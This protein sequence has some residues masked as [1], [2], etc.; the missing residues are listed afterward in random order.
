MRADRCAQRASYVLALTFV[1]ALAGCG[2]ARVP[3]ARGPHSEVLVLAPPAFGAAIASSLAS[4]L[5]APVR[6]QG[7]TEP[8]FQ[9]RTQLQS[10]E[11]GDLVE[12][13]LVLVTLLD[14]TPLAERVRRT[15]PA[16]D[17]ERVRDGGAGLFVYTD[18]WAREQVVV[19]VAA[20]RP[21]ALDSLVHAL[22]STFAIG[23]EAAVV[24]R[25]SQALRAGAPEGSLTP[26]EAETPPVRLALPEGYRRT[27]V[28]NGWGAARSWARDTPT[29]IVTLFW[30]DGVDPE[31]ASSS[32]FLLG[33]QRDALWR[34]NR[35]TLVE[36]QCR[37]ERE[38]PDATLSGVWQ[39]AEHVAGGPFVTR[40]VY[41]VVARRVYAIQGLLFAPGRPKHAFVRELRAVL[42]SFEL[43]EQT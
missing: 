16:H 25:W 34:M 39:N 26:G 6:Y 12:R 2:D 20:L 30:L 7:R 8:R 19:L 42:A 29:R 3:A 40:F 32:E 36:A 1:A 31:Q 11:R 4:A 41:D 15:F 35:D 38:A 28:A 33:L 43:G 24:G 10:P 5:R 37:F 13:H 22:G 9:V 14:A 27:A 17:L 18:V 21:A 23:Y